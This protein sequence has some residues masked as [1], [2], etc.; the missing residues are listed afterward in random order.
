MAVSKK[1]DSHDEEVATHRDVRYWT[2]LRV[3][4]GVAMSV[5][6]IGLVIYAQWDDVAVF[7]RGSP[8]RVSYQVGVAP[9]SLGE[10]FDFTNLQ[11]DRKRIVHGG[12]PK[13][14][15]PSITNPETVPISEA[16]FMRPTDRVVGVNING[17]SR[18]YPIKVLN[19]H[20]CI[21]DVLG[22]VPI[23]VVFC[24]LC[25]SV[26]VMDR[27]LDEN[28]YE[29]GISGF[30]YNSNVL[31]YDRTDHAL[32]SQVGLRAISG[33]N[34]GRSMRHYSDWVIT[35]FER[36]RETHPQSTIVTL[37]TGYYGPDRYNTQAYQSYFQT[38]EI[39]FPVQPRNNGIFP[40]KYP[41]IGVFLGDQAKAYPVS[42]IYKSSGGR[43]EDRFGDGRVVL[44]HDGLPG[45]VRVVEAPEGAQVVHTF[46]FAWYAFHPDTLIYQPSPEVEI[47]N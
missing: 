6:L 25:D 14:G 35:T 3:M 24:P 1:T 31:L 16:D 40:N 11:I 42:D 39:M 13:D 30:L 37:N 17:H 36:W 20:E 38:D 45:S 46:W 2:P 15:I 21:N 32:W 8:H 19:Y 22:G 7:L 10:Q 18:A 33:P 26:T 47:T 12:P 29:F 28:T 4:S 27:R 34:A 43:V 5:A 41:V 9:V 44:E 23:A